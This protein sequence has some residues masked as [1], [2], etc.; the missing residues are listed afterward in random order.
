MLEDSGFK[1]SR[2]KTAYKE[3]SWKNKS[4]FDTWAP[5]SLPQNDMDAEIASRIQSGWTEWRSLT[6]VLCNSKVPLPL[7]GCVYKVT[8]RP[9]QVYSAESWSTT[10]RQS[11]QLETQEIN[12]LRWMT[13]VMRMDKIRK[14]YVRALARVEGLR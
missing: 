5:P 11:K 8:V 13:G 3:H 10:S 6:G 12:M 2:E 1:I 4:F 7:K 14:E 9:A